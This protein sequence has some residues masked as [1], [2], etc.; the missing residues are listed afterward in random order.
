MM[1]YL[2]FFLS[3]IRHFLPLFTYIFILS[4]INKIYSFS[5]YN[6][7]NFTKNIPDISFFYEIEY[8]S[9]QNTKGFFINQV[10]Y[11]FYDGFL[12]SMPNRNPHQPQSILTFSTLGIS[13]LTVTQNSDNN[14]FGGS[15]NGN[16][17]DY[18]VE[19]T[20]N[21]NSGSTF[22]LDA[23]FSWREPSSG[24]IA[25]IGLEFK[26]NVNQ[27][28]NYGSSTFII[29][30]GTQNN[31]TSLGLK[32]PGSSISFLMVIIDLERTVPVVL[33]IG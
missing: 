5:D 14:Q 16:N 22:T 15:G 32:I 2:K 6:S 26:N 21:L 12:G 20:F 19:V 25:I 11:T 33:L 13:S 27:S 28:F 1:K 29:D 8:D 23:T 4:F 7:T 24:N 10:S 31:S 17:L 9:I 30:G 3:W 18:D